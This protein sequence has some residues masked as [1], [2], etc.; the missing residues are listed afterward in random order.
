[1]YSQQGLRLLLCKR[2]LQLLATRQPAARFILLAQPQLRSFSSIYSAESRDFSNGK[3]KKG[4]KKKEGQLSDTE[5]GATAQEEDSF[6][7]AREAKPQE[8]LKL[9]QSLFQPFTL[10]EVKKIQ[11][12][13]DHAPPTKEDTIPGRYAS[14]LFTTASQAGALYDVYEDMKYLSELYSHSESFQLFTQNAGVGMKE[15]KIFNTSLQEVGDFNALTIR[16]IEVLAE[17]KRLMYI[18]EIAEKYQK[19]YQL[20]NKE[21][22]ITIISANKLSQGEEQE[23]LKALKANPQNQGKEFVLEFKVDESILGGLQMYTE[24]EFMDMSLVSR[25]DKLQQEIQKMVD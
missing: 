17:N 16:F 18:K 3:K 13:P 1:M 6:A 12:T 25:L 10:G 23:V 7:A 8:D 2:G 21:E 22:K 5:G 24:S 4:G 11:S 15:V 20:F 14:V 19:L 9:E